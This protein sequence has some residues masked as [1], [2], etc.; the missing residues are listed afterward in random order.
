[1]LEPKRYRSV[2]R[3][4]VPLLR[5]RGAPLLGA[6]GWGPCWSS[7]ACRSVRPALPSSALLRPLSCAAVPHC[8]AAPLPKALR[9]F[10]HP[11]IV[12]ALCNTPLP[13]PPFLAPC[14]AQ[15]SDKWARHMVCR[16]DVTGAFLSRA[17]VELLLRHYPLAQARARG[18][19]MRGWVGDTGGAHGCR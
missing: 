3:P 9:P 2:S 17:A 18:G 13:P 12:L 11:L 10:P 6:W 14:P 4:L 7:G 8:A 19:C 1:M 5:L 15:L 16:S